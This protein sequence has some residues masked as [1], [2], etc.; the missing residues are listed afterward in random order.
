VND[1]DREKFATEWFANQRLLTKMAFQKAGHPDGGMD[2]LQKTWMAM[3]EGKYD[4]AVPV[5]TTARRVMRNFMSATRR[6]ADFKNTVYHGEGQSPDDA[7]G[8]GPNPEQQV[9]LERDTARIWT[10]IHD[11]LPPPGCLAQNLM[12]VG[13]A[14]GIHD[15]AELAERF[16]VTE[17]AVRRARARIKEK[18]IE[19][20]LRH[21][22]TPPPKKQGSGK[23][24]G[25]Q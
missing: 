7:G 17:V 23:K 8:K 22:L 18:T 6:T 24:E 19:V 12:V 1:D 13:K 25:D 20:F 16:S 21:G 9:V 5:V 10:E 4:P 2:L 14:E 11:G 15:T 3:Y